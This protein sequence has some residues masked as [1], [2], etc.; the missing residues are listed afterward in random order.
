MIKL[1]NWVLALLRRLEERSKPAERKPG[2]LVF[3]SNLGGPIHE[4]KFVG[5]HFKPLLRSAGLPNIRL[6]DL[7]EAKALIEA[8]RKEYNDSRPHASLADRTP[9]EFASQYAASRVLAE[10]KT[11]CGLTSNLVQEN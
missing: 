3:T 7:R 9:S 4:S 2:G 6:Y 1:Q 11:S 5:R 10:T 8:W